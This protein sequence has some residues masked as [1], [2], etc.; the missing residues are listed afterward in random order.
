MDVGQRR[1]STLR[2]V[3]PS[4][5]SDISN[6]SGTSEEN[7]GAGLVAKKDRAHRRIWAK[8]LPA[9]LTRQRQ[10]RTNTAFEKWKANGRRRISSIALL[11]IAA[12]IIMV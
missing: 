12:A 9:S 3:S 11:L 1:T 8:I 4:A 5:A 6:S 7:I 2:D 10:S